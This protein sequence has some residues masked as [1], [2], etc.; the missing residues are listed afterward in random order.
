MNPHYLHPTDEAARTLFSQSMQ[1]EIVMLNLLR[2]KET[3]DYSS[4]PELEPTKPISG[5]E[6]YRMYIDDTHPILK[7]SG[8]EVL[9]LGNASQFFIGPQD[10][11]WDMVMLV[12][13]HSL[14]AFLSFASNPDIRKAAGHREAALVDSRLLPISSL[15]QPSAGQRQKS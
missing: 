4:H 14:A 15:L 11:I 1:K 6:A 3:A 8:G 9:L 13:Q 12:K 7:E 2:F 10:E 5:R